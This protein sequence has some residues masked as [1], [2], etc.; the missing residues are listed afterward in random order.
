ME[1]TK[2]PTGGPKPMLR[3]FESHP[4][5]QPSPVQLIKYAQ[6]DFDTYR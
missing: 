5:I 2:K 3:L 1:T 6:L 4:S